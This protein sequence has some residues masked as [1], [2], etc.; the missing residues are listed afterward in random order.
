MQTARRQ[1]KHI[2]SIQLQLVHPAL[3]DRLRESPSTHSMY[4]TKTRVLSVRIG[5][6]IERGKEGERERGREGERARETDREGEEDREREGG[7]KGGRGK[8]GQRGRERRERAR[9]RERDHRIGDQ[10]SR[11]MRDGVLHTDQVLET[12]RPISVSDIYSTSGSHL[13]RT[14]TMKIPVNS[15]SCGNH[16]HFSLICL[17]YL[18]FT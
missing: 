12:R 7:M 4:V 14:Q 5:T 3:Y 18:K 15:K 2:E 1:A 17:L 6:G 10:D 8:M 11:T 9:A 13:I 16:M